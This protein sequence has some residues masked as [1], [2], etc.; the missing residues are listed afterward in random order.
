VI[1]KLEGEVSDGAASLYQSQCLEGLGDREKK[2]SWRASGRGLELHILLIYTHVCFSY[3]ECESRSF[4][5]RIHELDR[6]LHRVFDEADA[7]NTLQ[8][9]S[10]LLLHIEDR[11]VNTQVMESG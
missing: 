6:S 7:N 8:T 3:S 1:G 11:S 9:I 2:G 5:G 10:Y 4:G